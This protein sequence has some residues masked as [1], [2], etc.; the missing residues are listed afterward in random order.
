MPFAQILTVDK[1]EKHIEMNVMSRNIHK[2]FEIGPAKKIGQSTKINNVFLPTCSIRNY[3]L[4]YL[5]NMDK[6]VSNV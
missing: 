2:K 4:D 1:L 3:G 5:K 6:S